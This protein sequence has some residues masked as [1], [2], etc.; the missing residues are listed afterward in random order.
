MSY[1]LIS[2]TQP[3]ARKDHK[4]IWCGE[5]IPKGMKHQKEASSYNG[6]FQSSRF[7][8]ECADAATNYFTETQ[9]EE[10]SPGEFKRGAMEPK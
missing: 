1:T 9:E 3:V 5:P 2:K 6:D 8:I 4:C 7:H 10:F